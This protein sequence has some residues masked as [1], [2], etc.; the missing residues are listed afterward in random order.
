[1]IGV[2]VRLGF[3]GLDV[4]TRPNALALMI[5]GFPRQLGLGCWDPRTIEGEH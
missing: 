1:M 2:E 4:S 5:R 3:W